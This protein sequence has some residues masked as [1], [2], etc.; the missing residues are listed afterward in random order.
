MN[1]SCISEINLTLSCCII[2][3]TAAEKQFMIFYLGFLHNLYK[4][5]VVYFFPSSFIYLVLAS[6]SA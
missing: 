5:I 1:S 6:R 4:S 2:I 3:F